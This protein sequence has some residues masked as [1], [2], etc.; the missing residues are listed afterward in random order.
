MDS[1]Q[2]IGIDGGATKVSAWEIEYNGST[3]SLGQAHY[4]EQYI[5]QNF[6]NS[7][8][9]PVNIQTQLSEMNMNNIQLTGNEIKQ[10]VVIIQTFATVINRIFS[11]KPI[12]LGMGM[13]GLK[14]AD[15][16]GIV[17]MANGPRIPHFCDQLEEKL[18]QMNI[19]L[20]APIFQLGSDADYCGIGEEYASEG[21]FYDSQFGYYLGGGTGA[22]DA[23]KCDGKLV[24]L[25]QT[26][27]WLAKSW[28]LKTENKLSL[29]RYASAGGIQFVYSLKSGISVE[30]LNREGL[31]PNRILER[32][33]TGE[34]TEIETLKDVSHT[35]AKLYHERIETL[36]AGWQSPF[37][38]VNPNRAPLEPSHPYLGKVFDILI[39]GQRLGA[40][41]EKSKESI[42]LWRPFLSHLEMLISSNVKLDSQT[43]NHYLENGLEKMVHISQ[44]RDAPALGAGVDA[45]LH[46]KQS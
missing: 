46:Y 43:K 23:L 15:K 3:F 11:D 8:F 26:K 17:A 24:P 22:A 14:S 32:A 12:L 20:A 40:L 35:L 38:F 1:F 33:I 19:P 31:Y 4:A 18:S 16:R 29:E 28:E 42:Y 45:V 5:N 21:A 25:D 13:P 27:S 44:L 37:S 36:F 9:T 10:G 2:I 34:Y 41:M 6:F 7:S 30:E 39:I